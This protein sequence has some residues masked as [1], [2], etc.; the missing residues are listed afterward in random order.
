MKL[1]EG[2]LCIC[3]LQR[4]AYELARRLSTSFVVYVTDLSAVDV[5]D[6]VELNVRPS[7]KQVV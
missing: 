7:I 2:T 6:F 5:A 3:I 4:L 1:N